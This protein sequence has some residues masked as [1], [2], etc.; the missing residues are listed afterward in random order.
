VSSPYVQPRMGT[1]EEDTLFAANRNEHSKR[2]AWGD[3]HFRM[4]YKSGEVRAS[5]RELATAWGWTD[6]RVE[7]WLG[8]LADRGYIALRRLGQKARD[9]RVIVIER[10]NQRGKSGAISGARL[11]M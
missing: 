3:L 4:D 8:D 1:D 6:N 5:G 9:G 7:R 11:R 10:G 2:D